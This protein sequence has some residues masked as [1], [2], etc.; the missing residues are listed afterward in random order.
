VISWFA[1]AWIYDES[2][3]LAF[4]R[5]ISRWALAPVFKTRDIRGELRRTPFGKFVYLPKNLRRIVSLLCTLNLIMF[6][7]LLKS[8]IDEH[9]A[10][11][12]RTA[13]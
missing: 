1:F 3:D 13:S 9:F 2:W 12:F 11:P 5:L 7:Q 10:T 8:G 6:S 4:Y